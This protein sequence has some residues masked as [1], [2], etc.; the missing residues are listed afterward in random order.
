MV[1]FGTVIIFIGQVTASLEGV[2]TA[3]TAIAGI[4]SIISGPVI[5]VVAAIGAFIAILVVAWNT[6]E[7]FRNTIIS[8]WKAMNNRMKGLI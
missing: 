1:I 8:G 7:T 5:L 4:F 6:S 3:F 2:S